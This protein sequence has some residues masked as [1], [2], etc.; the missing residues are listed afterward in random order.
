M[1]LHCGEH[2]KSAMIRCKRRD[3]RYCALQ[4]K[5]CSL[6]P[7]DRP[8]REDRSHDPDERFRHRIAIRW[9]RAIPR[10][11][12]GRRAP[13]A[14]CEVCGARAG[15]GGR[16]ARRGPAGR[17]WTGLVCHL[18]RGAA[19]DVGLGHPPRGSRSLGRNGAVAGGGRIRRIPG[20]AGGGHSHEP[21]RN[22]SGRR[23]GRRAVRSAPLR[24][25]G[26]GPGRGG[27]RGADQAP[28]GRAYC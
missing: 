27:L 3:W 5:Y 14:S 20:A 4:R 21:G 17:A 9:A 11:D 22:R 16:R 2:P 25:R 10:G 23:A 8:S 18:R 12:H 19:A 26:G 28:V 6:Q 15:G 7:V 13:F 1:P 24:G